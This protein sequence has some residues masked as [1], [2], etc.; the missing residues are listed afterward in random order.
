MTLLAHSAGG[1]LARAFLADE[2]YFDA[3]E[4]H[5]ASTQHN[6]CHIP[7]AA[8]A[9]NLLVDTAAKPLQRSSRRRAC[10]GC[11]ATV[12]RGVL[13]VLVFERRAVRAIVS[14]GSPHVPAPVTARDM[15]GGALTWVNNHWPGAA[16]GAAAWRH[17][18]TPPLPTDCACICRL[19]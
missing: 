12:H 1:W 16:A 10:H 4:T 19:R 3:G 9:I 7:A 18:I 11:Q 14:L 15:T 5:A 2:R 8:E 6:R 17:P 13:N